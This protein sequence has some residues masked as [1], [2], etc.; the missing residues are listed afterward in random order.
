VN[1][2]NVVVTAAIGSLFALG[3][4]A[5][6]AA[7]KAPVEKCFGIVK[8]GKNDCRQRPA[9]APARRPRTDRRTHGFTFPRAPATKSSAPRSS[10]ASDVVSAALAGHPQGPI[11][12][13]C[14]IGLRAEHYRDLLERRPSLAFVEVHSENY[15]G[16]GGAPLYFLEQA[17]THY[18]LSLHGVGLSLGSSDP[19]D[20]E[21]LRRLKTLI[22]RYEP[23]LVSDHLSWSSVGG[24]FLNDLLPLPYTE[25]TLAHF[26]ARV[27]QA[28]DYL[29]RE[30]LIENPSSYLQYTESAIPEWEFLAAVARA[31]G[32]GLLLD[33]NNIY[34]SSQNTASTRT[35][36]SRRCRPRRS[37]RSTSPVTPSTATPRRDVD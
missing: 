29:G 26:S 23:A 18:P 2:H 6:A 19:L 14:G 3:S 30:L 13:R 1:H 34:V 37:A 35:A 9:P 10:P 24:V 27:A 33:V 7:D 28:Q 20:C 4:L 25:E 12:N 16:A 22:Q 36:I 31:S 32:C 11:P 15:F 8:A 21:H 5:A 17:R